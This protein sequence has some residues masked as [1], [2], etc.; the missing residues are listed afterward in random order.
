[1]FNEKKLHFW[2]L[3]ESLFFGWCFVL[4]YV[5]D[6]HGNHNDSHIRAHLI[7]IYPSMLHPQLHTCIPCSI[8][9]TV[10]SQATF[11]WCS[12]VEQ[13]MVAAEWRGKWMSTFSPPPSAKRNRKH[14]N[15]CWNYLSN[16]K[17]NE[18]W[19]KWH[20][21]ALCWRSEYQ[22]QNW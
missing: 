15:T 4:L 17:K 20:G 18:S 3:L 21:I 2:F 13:R 7:N 10:R 14:S 22:K 19:M 8:K 16:T 9:W 12:H 11:G 1:M 5:S 6:F